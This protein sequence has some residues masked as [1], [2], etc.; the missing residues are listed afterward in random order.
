MV[1]TSTE[2]EVRTKIDLPQLASSVPSTTDVTRAHETEDKSVSIEEA[3]RG[4]RPQL[5]ER[6]VF[7]A[8]TSVYES[9]LS[10]KPEDIGQRIS[11]VHIPPLE[12]SVRAHPVLTNQVRMLLRTLWAIVVSRSTQLRFPLS[13]TVVSVF[14]DPTEGESKAVLRLSCNASISQALAFWDSLEPDLQ[15]WLNNLTE[16]ERAVFITKISLRVYWL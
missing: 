8:S 16:Y 10:Q 3:Y 14:I 6:V 11:E 1:L 12:W 9:T 13:K 2:P 5:P 15:S 7:A 4:L